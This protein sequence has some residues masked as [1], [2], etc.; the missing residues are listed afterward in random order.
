MTHR[1]SRRRAAPESKLESN[2]ASKSRREAGQSVRKRLSREWTES[3]VSQQAHVGQ[4]SLVQLIEQDA[5]LQNRH[6]LVLM[7]GPF[8]AEMSAAQGQGV[9]SWLRDCVRKH[10]LPSLLRFDQGRRALIFRQDQ[11]QSWL[12]PLLA[13]VSS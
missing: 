5:P 11:L 12:E 6:V 4:S 2:P 1:R 13:N 9:G 7:Y 10:G 3:S 8:Q